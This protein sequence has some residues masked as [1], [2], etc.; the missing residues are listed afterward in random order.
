MHTPNTSAIASREKAPR[1]PRSTHLRFRILQAWFT[2]FFNTSSRF[3]GSMERGWTASPSR[4]LREFIASGKN[5]VATVYGAKWRTPYM[6]LVWS[7]PSKTSTNY[8]VI[9]NECYEQNL[10]YVLCNILRSMNSTSLF[11]KLATVLLYWS[12]NITNHNL[13]CH[14]KVTFNMKNKQ[15]ML[16]FYSFNGGLQLQINPISKWIELESWD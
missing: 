3:A 5:S 10:Y 13:T 12:P 6:D 9:N 16:I 11:C 15:K 7:K 2:L 14:L 1:S 4:L 8:P